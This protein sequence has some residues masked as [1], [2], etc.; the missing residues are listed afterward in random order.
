MSI[1]F[2]F[3]MLQSIVQNVDRSAWTIMSDSW[4]QMSITKPSDFL[5]ALHKYPKPAILKSAYSIFLDKFRA[6]D[7][8]VVNNNFKSKPDHFNGARP[9]YTEATTSKLPTYIWDTA[10]MQPQKLG[11]F[12]TDT[13][14]RVFPPDETKSADENELSLITKT[15]EGFHR[16][17]VC[18]EFVSLFYCC[19][20]YACNETNYKDESIVGTVAAPL[21][22]QRDLAPLTFRCARNMPIDCFYCNYLLYHQQHECNRLTPILK[23]DFCANCE[24]IMDCTVELRVRQVTSYQGPTIP[25]RIDARPFTHIVTST[26]DDQDYQYND[27]YIPE[28]GTSFDLTDFCMKFEI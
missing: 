9:I 5:R 4:S 25:V 6:F 18:S 13:F 12:A 26:I 16:C 11:F 3:D 22:C 21:E 14:C 28:N 1:L 20:H 17:A 8:S 19:Y 7:K 24:S 15:D 2:P 23:E 10:I 27:G